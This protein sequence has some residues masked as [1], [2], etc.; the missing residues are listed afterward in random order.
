MT[1]KKPNIS[2]VT[3][4]LDFF[5]FDDI[6]DQQIN[7][8]EYKDDLESFFDYENS[9][10]NRINSFKNICKNSQLQAQEIVSDLCST[11]IFSPVENIFDLFKEIITLDELDVSI[12][13]IICTCIYNV[14]ERR[15]ESYNLFFYLVTQMKNCKEL[16]N[17]TLYLDVL[18][19]LINIE[20]KNYHNRLKELKEIID[21]MCNY[22]SDKDY[23]NQI[24]K[25]IYTLYKDDKYH[26]DILV[27]SM[28]TIK[29]NCD[30][31]LKIVII[32]HLFNTIKEN[33]ILELDLFNELVNISNRNE[34]ENT[35]ADV[36]D[37]LLRFSEEKHKLVGINI[38]KQLE[39]IK[40]KRSLYENSQNIHHIN[41]DGTLKEFLEFL[42][43]RQ[44]FVVVKGTE[45]EIFEKSKQCLL[46]NDCKDKDK[47]QQSLHR[48]YLDSTIYNG[49]TML[50]IYVK[51]WLVI[52]CHNNTEQLQ[53]RLIEELIEMSDTCSTGH[54]L[55]LSNVFSGF[56][57]TLKI[58]ISKEIRSK[59]SHLINKKIQEENDEK[60]L[61]IIDNITSEEEMNLFCKFFMKNIDYIRQE[62][63]I[64]YEKI[65]DKDEFEE[66]FRKELVFYETNGKS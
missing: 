35:K 26:K 41:V 9:I 33:G 31:R 14:E 11:F 21:F 60:Q 10:E 5:S 23:K 57:F 39:G 30:D 15:D 2:K 25:S 37:L 17:S 19:Y 34:D 22:S 4:L 65:L 36:A 48:I 29:N 61:E 3:S 18:R 55:R 28:V 56:G 40:G 27:H 1:D 53:Q 42:S 44:T 59:V 45:D 24:Y 20:N 46:K 66:L 8:R 58:D 54:L 43:S 50:T 62:I 64:D 13:L 47:I 38:L 49:F 63:F 6:E 7:T 12:K 32:T 16:F 52:E 51:V